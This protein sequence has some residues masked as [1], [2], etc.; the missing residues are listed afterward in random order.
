MKSAL[1]RAGL[2]T[3]NDHFISPQ[4][5]TMCRLSFLFVVL[6]VVCD[7]S[8][9]GG[10]VFTGDARKDFTPLDPFARAY[11]DPLHEVNVAV[12]VL[13]SGWDISNVLMSYDSS[14]DK[15]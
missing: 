15:T 8:H 6:V 7:T 11:E 14:L 1:Y 5:Y 2:A 9:C 3:I 12:P 10:I 13:D 4:L